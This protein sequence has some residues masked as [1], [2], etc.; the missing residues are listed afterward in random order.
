MINNEQE[1]RNSIA[2][3]INILSRGKDTLGNELTTAQ[4]VSI[5]RSI[6]NAQSKLGEN[7]IENTAYVIEDVTPTGYGN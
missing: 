1:I 3:G 7:R 5:R 6:L 4:R 2:E